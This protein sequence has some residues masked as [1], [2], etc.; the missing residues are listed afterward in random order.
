MRTTAARGG[1]RI[2]SLA[3]PVY[4]WSVY[5]QEK[6]LQYLEMGLGGIITGYPRLLEEVLGSYESRHAGMEYAHLR[7]VLRRR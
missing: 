3:L 1:A 6:M 5:D 7:G 2:A 4:V